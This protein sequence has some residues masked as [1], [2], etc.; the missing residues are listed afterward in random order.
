[1]NPDG[2]LFS[3]AWGRTLFISIWIAYSTISFL[4]YRWN[5]LSGGS[6]V[7]YQLTFLAL[8]LLAWAGYWLALVAS[9]YL[10]P[11]SLYRYCGLFVLSHR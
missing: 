1:M 4:L 3:M 11:R 6:V 8:P 9:P 2:S 7:P 5:A 10:R